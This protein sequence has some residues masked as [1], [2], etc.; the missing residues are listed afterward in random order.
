MEYLYLSA[1]L[2]LFGTFTSFLNSVSTSFALDL[3][4]EIAEKYPKKYKKLHEIR[5]KS[6]ITA[7]TFNLLELCFY[8][9]ATIVASE[10]VFWVTNNI[11]NLFYTFLILALIII[12]FKIISIFIGEKYSD[13]LIHKFSSIIIFLYYLT[14]PIRFLLEKLYLFISKSLNEDQ[15]LEELNEKVETAREEGSIEPGEYKI[16][17]NIM[18]F[19]DVLVSDV[20]TPRIV[21]FSCPANKT[22]GEI[23]NLPELQMYSRF[24]IWEG[25]SLDDGVVGYVMSKDVLLSA[26]KGNSNATLKSLAREIFFIPENVGLD[27]ALD[28]FLRQRQ[29]IFLVVDEYGGIEGL[30]TMEDVMETILGEEIVDEADKFIDLR[31]LAKQKRD[32]RI[33]T[34]SREI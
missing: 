8:L 5:Y 32:K 27:K 11:F 24:P 21:V 26:V 31:E 1:I 28:A 25:N 29:H 16:L 4:N 6:E 33:S 7:H 20:M 2:I 18:R 12:I 9:A 23:L 22:V 30:I 3:L 15:S 13:N 34:F 14:Y 19:S 17:K 10:T